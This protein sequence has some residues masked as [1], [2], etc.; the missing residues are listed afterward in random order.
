SSTTCDDTT[1]SPHHNNHNQ[2]LFTDLDNAKFSKS[3]VQTILVAGSG[4]LTDAYDVVI[5][6]LMVPMIAY[7]YYGHAAL[8]NDVADGFLKAASSFGNLFGQFAFGL[9]GDVWGRKK[10]YGIVLVILIIGAIGSALAAQPAVGLDILAILGF[11]RFI[12]GLGIGGDYPVSAVITSE[13]ASTKRRGTMIATVFSMQGVGFLLA[14]L[15]S[16]IFLSAFK[17]AILVDKVNLD[18]VWRLLAGFGAVPA[19]MAVYYR[20][21]LPETP[22]FAADVLNDVERSTKAAQTFLGTTGKDSNIPPI[23]T[24]DVPTSTKT[25]SKKP[26]STGT[27][28]QYGSDFYMYFR[29][30]KNLRT[31]LGCSLTWFFLDIGY[32]GTNLNTSLVLGYIGYNDKSSVFNDV[33]SRAVGTV[34]INL[35][36]TFP[37]YYFTVYFIDKWGRKPIQYMGFTMLTITF[38]VMAVGFERL[39]EKPGAFIFLYALAQFFFNF[40]PNTTT[41]TIP[42]EC[43]PTKVRSTAHGIAAASGKLGAILA[44]LCFSRLANTP[45]IGIQGV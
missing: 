12:L 25:N 20:M 34:I 36:G 40:G 41:F 18:Y 5:I 9:A 38:F 8:P 39:K 23:E 24:A 31:L 1:N 19:L 30:W 33:W 15:M 26:K 6:G 21:T 37:G 3:H 42:A 10:M 32:Y 11:W 22:R 44:A 7:V 43:F 4:F 45:A 29:H 17:A 28:K 13:F 14:A 2:T 16:V 27:F 35:A